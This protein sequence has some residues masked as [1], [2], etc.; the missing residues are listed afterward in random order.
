[1]GGFASVGGDLDASGPIVLGR[2]PPRRDS[3]AQTYRAAMVQLYKGWSVHGGHDAFRKLE[4]KLTFW[5][6]EHCEEEA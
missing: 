1:M 2:R 6:R 5:V 3:L 4:R